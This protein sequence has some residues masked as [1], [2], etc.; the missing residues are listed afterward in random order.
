MKPLKMAL[1]RD[2][3]KFIQE[4]IK[5]LGAAKRRCRPRELTCRLGKSGDPNAIFIYTAYIYHI[6]KLWHH[7]TE[8][9]SV[10]IIPL[11][12]IGFLLYFLPQSQKDGKRCFFCT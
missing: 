8:C 6:H 10:L 12:S 3:C 9:N 7:P 2:L 11:F 1:A 5:R 4:L